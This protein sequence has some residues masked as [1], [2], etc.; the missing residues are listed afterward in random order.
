MSI[1]YTQPQNGPAQIDWSNPITRGMS[2]CVGQDKRNL[3]SNKQAT[4]T[5]TKRTVGAKGVANGFGATF[6]AGTTDAI[7][8]D[9]TAHSQQ[10]TYLTVATRNGVGGGSGGRLLE[11]RTA[12]AVVEAWYNNAGG[13][14]IDFWK[15]YSGANALYNVPV[16]TN[17]IPFAM[18]ISVN[19]DAPTGYPSCY[20]DGKKL[21]VA[22]TTSSGTVTTNTDAYVIGNRTN[23]S[24]RNWDGEIYLTVF[25]DRLLNESELSS[26]TANPW[27]IFAPI[28]RQLFVPA[29]ASGASCT[30][31]ATTDSPTNAFSAQSIP[32]SAA[33]FAA[34]TADVTNAFAAS[35]S[36]VTSFAAT[37]DSPSAIFV[38]TVSPVVSF[39]ATTGAVTANF[40]AGVGTGCAFSVTTE[41]PTNAFSAE[42][43]APDSSASFSVTTDSPI[44]NLSASVSPVAQ[45]AATSADA[46]FVGSASG[47]AALFTQ[48]QLDY[49]LAY[50]E[51][52]MA[53]PTAAEIAA[54]VVAQLN[55]TTIPVD[56]QKTNGVEIIGDGSSANKFRSI[57]A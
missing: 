32:P 16:P 54:E 56:M 14:T 45:F 51:A 23:D 12:G 33:S 39:N 49:L 46:I 15:Q 28:R 38:A 2:L 24:A 5:G 30:F 8:T 48:E 21:T 42:V 44:G 41:A 13:S 31:T 20:R 47:S 34:A 26:V 9:L 37:T 4:V 40:S 18:A 29:A 6:G 43:V 11:K 52:N 1:R 50:M 55:A 17:N 53:V 3:I 22:G 36:P 25:W 27:Q 57:N 10:R 19:G 35:V 7:V